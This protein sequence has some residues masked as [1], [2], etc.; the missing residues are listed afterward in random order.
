MAKIS[1][2]TFNPMAGV[3]LPGWAL[4]SYKATA[5]D[6]SDVVDSLTSAYNLQQKREADMAFD[7]AKLNQQESQFN[8]QMEFSKLSDAKDRDF[9]DRQARRQRDE[10]RY[11]MSLEE[12]RIVSAARKDRYDRGVDSND[13]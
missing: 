8:E 1:T 4:Q 10:H 9:A 13:K 6:L 12:D 7:V 11:K 5:G 3:S 2:K